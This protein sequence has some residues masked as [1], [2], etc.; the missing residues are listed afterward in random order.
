MDA[1]SSSSM[2]TSRAGDA[3]CDNRAASWTHNM[4][5]LVGGRGCGVDGAALRKTMARGGG[6]PRCSHGSTRR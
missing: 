6:A 5:S 1:S 3:T 4:C 2:S